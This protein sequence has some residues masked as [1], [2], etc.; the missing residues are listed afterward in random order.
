MA[1]CDILCHFLILCPLPYSLSISS[2]SVHFL[3]LCPFPHSLCI[4]SLSVHFLILCPFPNSLSISSFSV[5]FLI[6][7]PSPLNFL[8]LSPFP[9]SPAA[10]LQQVAQPCFFV[11][12]HYKT[13]VYFIKHSCI[14]HLF[15]QF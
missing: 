9:R 7:S 14:K 11:H 10:R 5:H 1:T 13:L 15:V 2:F 12:L 8:I 3:I 4:S 6:L